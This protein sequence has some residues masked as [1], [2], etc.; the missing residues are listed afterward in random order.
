MSTPQMKKRLEEIARERVAQH[1]ALGGARHRKPRKIGGASF[2]GGLHHSHRQEGGSFASDLAH[3][4]HKANDFAKKTHIVSH[5]AAATGNPI[6]ASAARSLG[7]GKSHRRVCKGCGEGLAYS[8]GEGMG[9]ARGKAGVNHS[10]KFLDTHS[11]YVP[12]D[13]PKREPSEWNLFIKK[14]MAAARRDAMAEIKTHPKLYDNYI[15][16]YVQAGAI[17][18]S[19]SQFATRLAMKNLAA[20]FKNNV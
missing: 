14:Y 5:V 17:P 20:E 8:T 9:G 1:D 13:K 3:V 6:A 7:Y 19:K 2:G 10:G 15:H 16:D 12:P 11:K 18:P 4:A